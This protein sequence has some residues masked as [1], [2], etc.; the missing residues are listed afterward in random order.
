MGET[1]LGHVNDLILQTHILML[2]LML[3]LFCSATLFA[4]DFALSY[5]RPDESRTHH[6]VF[7]EDPI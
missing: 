5:P 2:C 1:C 7:S 3:H 4:R 6:T